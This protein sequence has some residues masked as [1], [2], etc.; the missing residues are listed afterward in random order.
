M[1][2]SQK[3]QNNIERLR[4]K[5]DLLKRE[6]AKIYFKEFVR[7]AILAGM[8][9]IAFAVGEC[10]LTYGIAGFILYGLLDLVRVI[11]RDCRRLD[12]IDRELYSIKVRLYKRK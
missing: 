2:R 12:K 8:G 4:A 7:V 5:I 6:E 11:N 1:R 9:I 10:N 3:N